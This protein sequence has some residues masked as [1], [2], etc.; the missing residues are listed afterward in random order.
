MIIV[1]GGREI[2]EIGVAL[3]AIICVYA[4]AYMMFI[5]SETISKHISYTGMLVITRLLGLL[6]SAIAVGMIMTGLNSYFIKL[7][8]AFFGDPMFL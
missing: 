2:I 8:S 4:I 5:S 7:L 6:L 3:V 1:T